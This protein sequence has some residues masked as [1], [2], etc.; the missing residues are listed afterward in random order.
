MNSLMMTNKGKLR[1][2]IK[3]KWL[4]ALR[5]GKFAQGYGRLCEETKFG[6]RYCCLGVLANIEGINSDAGF[7]SERYLPKKIQIPLVYRNDGIGN[8][9]VAWSFRRIATWIEKNL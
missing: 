8:I 2:P 3:R 1:A 9:K 6:A 7:L 5:S 4:E